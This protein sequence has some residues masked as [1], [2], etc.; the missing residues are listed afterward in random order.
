MMQSGA[1]ISTAV[2]FFWI[3]LQHITHK[4]QKKNHTPDFLPLYIYGV[5]TNK[6][7]SSKTHQKSRFG[8]LSVTGW[9]IKV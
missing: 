3:P 1:S 5:S 4:V 9:L 7:L 6:L 2:L 8:G